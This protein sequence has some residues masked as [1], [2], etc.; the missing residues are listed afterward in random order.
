MQLIFVDSHGITQAERVGYVS[1][2]SAIQHSLAQQLQQPG[3]KLSISA[4]TVTSRVPW[5]QQNDTDLLFEEANRYIESAIAPPAGYAPAAHRQEMAVALWR[6]ADGRHI[7]M[8]QFPDILSDRLAQVPEIQVG[9]LQVSAAAGQRLVEQ[10]PHTIQFGKEAFM[11]KTGDSVT[12]PSVSVMQPD[13]GR[14]LIGAVAARSIALPAGSTYMAAFSRNSGSDRVVD[15]QVM[16]LPIVE[17]TQ[18]EVAA[19]S[20]GRS[21]LTFDYEPHTAYGVR[22]GDIVIAQAEQGGE[23]VALRV[24]GQH[25]IDERLAAQ[26]GAAQR[27]AEVEK[28]AP[29]PIA[30]QLAAARSEGK[31]LWGLNVEPLGSYRQGQITPFSMP[32]QSQQV[33]T[34][35]APQTEQAPSSVNQEPP[36]KPVSLQLYER[37]SSQNS[38]VLSAVAAGNSQLQQ[39][40][41]S[42]MAESAIADG[43]ATEAVQD[44]IAQHSPAAQRSG[45][46]KTYAKNVVRYLPDHTDKTPDSTSKKRAQAQGRNPSKRAKAKDNGM[47]Y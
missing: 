43:H 14:F 21:H 34:Q 28:A 27:W 17:Q 6:Q 41:D 19:F 7:V 26:A 10:S 25:R 44:A 38:G 29:P 8:K 30:E 20:E 36:A 11:T 33:V 39:R 40:L 5:A 9:R 31:E 12:L 23:P 42:S 37:Y 1:P 24:G 18:A 45:Q 2:E 46:P 4:P 15:M 47:G 32:E 3:Q 13:G 16:D 22:E 35:T